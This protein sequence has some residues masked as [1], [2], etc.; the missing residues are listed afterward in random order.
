[1]Q[2]SSKIFLLCS[3][4]LGTL[5][6]WLPVV[7]SMSNM[8]NKLN[9]TLIIPDA[10]IVR[11]F[12]IDN[13]M[14]KI[15]NNIFD[16]VLIHAYDDIWIKHASVLDS[17]KWYQNNHITLRLFSILRRLSNKQFFSYFLTWVLILLRNKIYKK[18]FKINYKDF[19]GPVHHADILLYDVHVEANRM[20]SN[21]LMLFD[22][23]NKYSL[24]HAL[25]LFVHSSKPKLFNINN[26]DNLKV[27]IYTKS[28]SKHYDMKYDI[29]LDKIRIVGIPRHDIKW[30]ETVQ[31]ESPSLPGQFKNDNTILIFS[32][33]ATKAHLLFNKKVESVK[34]IKK[35]FIDSMG[36]KVVIKIHPN[37]KHEALSFKGSEN[38][39]ENIFGLNNYGITWIYSDLHPFAL[40]KGKKLAISFNTG[41]VLDMVAMGVPCVEYI[42]STNNSKRN[43][44]EF[45]EYG[46]I[47]RA[48]NEKELRIFVNKWL[49][50]PNKISML[51]SNTYKEFLP[52][53]DNTSGNIATEILH[54]N[55]IHI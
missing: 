44:T 48:S 51:S 16:E 42:E 27:Y 8:L 18:K 12:S 9:F 13:A 50:N 26:K 34:N 4:H 38:I 31:N 14:V 46:F 32:R 37:E 39:Y 10:T 7:T 40:G 21:I 29:G 3:P 28:Q 11:S 33:N 15:S 45:S 25:T 24:P 55:G 54:D 23:S 53:I 47:E 43:V 49:Q 2:R 19:K 20:I 52:M 36:M 5:D 41:V 17:M 6:N 35:L 1:M 22:D 30:I